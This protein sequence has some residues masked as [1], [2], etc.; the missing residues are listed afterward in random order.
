MIKGSEQRVIKK[1]TEIV[2]PDSGW[3]KLTLQFCIITIWDKGLTG[4]T[5]TTEFPW[6]ITHKKEK[7]TDVNYQLTLYA[8]KETDICNMHVTNSREQQINLK[9]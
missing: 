9:G 5:E 1:L 8:T 4:L 2:S 3:N 6:K 7:E